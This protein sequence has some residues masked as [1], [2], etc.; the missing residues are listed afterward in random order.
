MSWLDAH[1][2]F[3]MDLVADDRVRELQDSIDPEIPRPE[4]AGRPVRD[5]A[6]VLRL[7]TLV[8]AT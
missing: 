7:P 4:P 6:G 5:A 3:F 2:S 1:E 8:K